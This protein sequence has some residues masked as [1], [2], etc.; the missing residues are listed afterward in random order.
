MMCPLSKRTPEQPWGTG[1]ADHE[2]KA[3]HQALNLI[4]LV[5]AALRS[6]VLFSLEQ[7]F[8][9]LMF[10]I[11]FFKTLI[12]AEGIH[13]MVFD[14]CMYGL[15]S[16]ENIDLEKNERI[17]KKTISSQTS[18]PSLTSKFH[19]TN[20]MIMCMLSATLTSTTPGS[21][22]PRR[23]GIIRMHYVPEWRHF[24]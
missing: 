4:R 22:D 9:S 6:K 1:L 18:P 11:D 13:T 12:D 5:K 14:Q 17:R 16:P 24:S 2:N 15:A 3:K 20:N 21:S 19:T 8:R 10:H 7:P 23:R